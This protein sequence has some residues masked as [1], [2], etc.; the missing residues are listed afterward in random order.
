MD[1][2]DIRHAVN[3]STDT[4]EFRTLARTVASIRG[5][6]VEFV[7]GRAHFCDSAQDRTVKY[8]V[9]TATTMRELRA[10]VPQPPKIH[11]FNTG[12]RY[13]IHGQRIAW[14]LLSTGN[15]FMFDIDRQIR[16]VLLFG[17]E[18]PPQSNSDVLMMYDAIAEAPWNRAEIE[19]AQKLIPEL[20]AAAKG[21]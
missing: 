19:E 4:P 5:W 16:Y 10:L 2:Q 13:T 15:V 21:V 11:A 20:E 3:E 12:R 8:D 6:A 14:T 17:L 1:N 18:L 9:A 7:D